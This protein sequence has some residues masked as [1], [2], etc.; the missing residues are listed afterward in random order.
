M[1]TQ[2]RKN[3]FNTIFRSIGSLNFC[4]WSYLVRDVQHELPQGEFGNP[5]ARSLNEAWH[6]QFRERDM[7]TNAHY[8]AVVRRQAASKIE[9]FGQKVGS[10]FSR[11]NPQHAEAMLKK[12]LREMDEVCS[13]IENTMQPYGLSALGTR[14][15]G[16]GGLVNDLLSFLG[17]LLNLRWQ[18]LA[19]PLAEIGEY[20]PTRRISFGSAIEIRGQSPEQTRFC[21][22]LSIAQYNEATY[23]GIFNGLLSI[24]CSFIMTQSFLPHGRDFSLYKFKRQQDKMRQVDDKAVSLMVDLNE[25]ADDVASGRMVY[26]DHHCTILCFEKTLE[27]LHD[28]VS[29]VDA[30]LREVGLVLRKEDLNKEASF[31][32]QLPANYQ[33][34]ARKAGISSKNFAGYSSFHNVPEGRLTGNHWGECIMAIETTGGTPYYFN[35]HHRDIGISLILGS[36]GTG[37]TTFMMM[38][39]LQTLK[40]GGQRFLFDKDDGCLI[41]VRAAGGTYS[42]INRGEPTGFNPFQLEDTEQNRGFLVDLLKVMAQKSLQRS[43]RQE[44][45]AVLEEVVRQNYHLDV[46]HR[47]LFHLR[48]FIPNVYTELR[49][50]IESWCGDGAYAWIFDHARDEVDFS[51]P[52]NAFGMGNI[53]EDAVARTVI[54]MYLFYRVELT[55]D[56]G[57]RTVIAIDEMWKYLQDEE[58]GA[59]VNDWSR[60]IRKKNGVLIG[61]TQTPDEILSNK[62][63]YAFYQQCETVVFFPN[64]KADRELYT[65]KLRF[66]Q[67]E[68]EIIKNTPVETR[69]FLL[70]HGTD[71]VICRFDL[72]RLKAFIPVLSAR[73]ETVQYME[74]LRRELGESPGQWLEAF[75]D[76]AGRLDV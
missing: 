33:Y 28:T 46:E 2:A 5:F 35:L 49:S 22:L 1:K 11:Y 53:L 43:V 73:K 69:Q 37:K 9:S 19:I 42:H 7:Y 30:T 31:W 75:M 64:F 27:K 48:R 67:R 62:N 3:T 15:N 66:S 21:A 36:T 23:P 32:A 65:K 63:G 74:R 60:T 40:Y 12:H 8:L 6:A 51:S 61:A 26:G 18:P 29:L 54:S 44:E 56:L 70:R 17:L 52:V 38:V 72:S 24:P 39:F 4:F 58:F 76:G 59:R 57:V 34:I 45:A 13:A 47:R 14:E 10:L 41:A 50:A 25:A 68:Y 55:L 16:H 20:L 71:S